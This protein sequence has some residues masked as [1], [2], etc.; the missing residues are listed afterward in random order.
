MALFLTT[1]FLSVSFTFSK[2]LNQCRTFCV[3]SEISYPPFGK[4]TGLYGSLT[5]V[6]ISSKSKEEE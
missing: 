3:T 4:S 5:V 1:P 2:F 6:F